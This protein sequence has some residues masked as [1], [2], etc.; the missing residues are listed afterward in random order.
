MTVRRPHAT[1]WAVE[2]VRALA[3]AAAWLAAALLFSLG[4]AGIV[5]GV[6]G[7][8]GSASRP[9]LTS[10]GDKAI[11]PGLAE[12]T[13]D[14]EE[15]ATTV[16]EVGE[17]ARLGLA[18][19]V[20]TDL[21]LLTAA[22]DAGTD[23]VADASAQASAL[24]ARL[25]ALPGIAP[26][27]AD[28][29]PPPA[30]LR[31]GRDMR[32]RFA[33][34]YGA[35]DATSELPAD[36]ARFASG[37]LVA[38][39]L[40]EVLLDHDASTGEAAK[41]GGSGRYADALKRLDASDALIATARGAR[42]KLA[43]TVDVATLTE[44]VERNAAYDG[45]LRDLYDALG[46]SKGKVND[47]VRAAFAAEQ[48]ARD[49]LPPD[50]RGLVIILAEVARGGMNQAAISIEDARIQLED[51]LAAAEALA[52]EPSASPGAATTPEP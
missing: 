24:R 16:D 28:P 33:L 21:D 14:L 47:E 23:R 37:S 26:D 17:Q 38:Q 9:E 8:P 2:R 27:A 18:A 51:A 44:W 3:L 50:T 22:I 4:A 35:L 41:L 32:D 20:A 49:R 15:I 12:A 6:G 31:L 42:D 48:A 5:A 36:W 7:Y 11:A 39:G 46:R 29:L 45:A 40:T 30:E 25:L 10:N 19:L 1:I 34:I 52:A 13:G 43:N